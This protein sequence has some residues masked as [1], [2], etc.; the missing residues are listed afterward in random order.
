MVVREIDQVESRVLSAHRRREAGARKAKQV[1][2]V[3]RHTS[4]TRPR[5]SA[6]LRDWPSAGRSAAPGDRREK[7]GTTM[8]WQEFRRDAMIVSPTA[9]SVNVVS[10]ALP[11]RVALATR[12]P[13]HCPGGPPGTNC[14]CGDVEHA[15]TAVAASGPD[16]DERH[17]RAHRRPVRHQHSMPVRPGKTRFARRGKGARREPG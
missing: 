2:R 12:S 17:Q 15:T 14:T 5:W 10:A 11:W 7:V 9:D 3:R 4:S 1:V 8:R 6:A 13:W 16:N